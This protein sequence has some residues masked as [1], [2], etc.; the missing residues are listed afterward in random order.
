MMQPIKILTLL[1]SHCGY[2]LLIIITAC[3]FLDAEFNIKTCTIHCNG[4]PVVQTCADAVIEDKKGTIH[5]FSNGNDSG[6]TYS[7]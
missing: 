5:N 4:R 3:Y 6:H 1:N 2:L 7:Y